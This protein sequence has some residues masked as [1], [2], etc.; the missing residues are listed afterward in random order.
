MR[1]AL[2]TYSTK[3]RGGVVHTLALAEAL[4]ELGQD[5]EVWTLGRG[6]DAGFFRPVDPAVR[7]RLVPFEDRDGES[8]GPRIVRSIAELTTA[9]RA[10]GLT[11]DVVHAQDCLSANAALAVRPDVLRT[12]HHIDQFSTPELVACHEKALREPARHVC[13]SRSVA[14]ELAAGWGI[15]ATVIPNGVDA[16]RFAS[17]ADPADP[18][19]AGQRAGWRHKL[20]RYVLAVGGIEPRKGTADLVEAMALLRSR[21]PD[22]ALVL[23]GGDT[24]FDYRGYRDDVLARAAELGVEPVLLGPVAHDELPA[25]MAGADVFAFPSTKEGFGLAAMEALAAGVP[26]VLR[27]LPVLREVFGGTA[28]FADGPETLADALAGALSETPPHV[29]AVER[30]RALAGV[31]LARRHTWSAAAEAHLRLYRERPGGC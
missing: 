28:R 13:V 3:P 18:V 11:A 2:L 1:I 8:M 4:V 14:A 9:L 5:V 20:G 15:R 24:L 12:V 25:L 31:A 7:V 29:A 6:G 21:A 10:D 30:E 26:V 23:A 27:D 19:A 22:V 16:D 17:A